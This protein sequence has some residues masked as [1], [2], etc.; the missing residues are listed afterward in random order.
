MKAVVMLMQEIF[1][2]VLVVCILLVSTLFNRSMRS[3]PKLELF[4]GFR[5]LCLKGIV[6]QNISS[7]N[8][9]PG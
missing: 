3:S 8:Y 9:C 6:Y 4:S 1:A 7:R 5:K 2:V